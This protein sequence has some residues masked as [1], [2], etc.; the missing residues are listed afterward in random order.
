MSATKPSEI[1][2]NGSRVRLWIPG[3]F[4]GEAGVSRGVIAFIPNRA[5]HLPKKEVR[6]E[7]DGQ[8]AWINVRQ[9]GASSM[10]AGTFR[11]A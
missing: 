10:F 11:L 7:I 2:D 4:E 8:P 3:V 1:I 5:G 6:G 9:C